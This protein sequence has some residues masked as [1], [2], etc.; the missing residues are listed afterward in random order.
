MKMGVSEEFGFARF[1]LHRVSPDSRLGQ[2]CKGKATRFCRTGNRRIDVA[3]G[4]P[5]PIFAITGP[6]GSAVIGSAPRRHHSDLAVS[7]E[8]HGGLSVER[9]RW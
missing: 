1:G 8:R 9:W 4:V 7:S 6:S 5:K 3:S 2:S